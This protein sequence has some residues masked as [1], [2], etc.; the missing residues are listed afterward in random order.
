MDNKSQA[1]VHAIHAVILIEYSESLNSFIN[2][3]KY[4]CKACELD[5]KTP[6]WFHINA[7][8]M[9][10]QRQFV[11]T[12]KLEIANIGALYSYEELCPT[13]NDINLAIRQAVLCLDGKRTCSVHSLVL[14]ALNQFSPMEIQPL[15]NTLPVIKPINSKYVV[16][17]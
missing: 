3:C 11:L 15:P 16:R 1:A 13:E 5:P 6:Q 9:A 2:A 4:A 14:T 8:V 17:L 7:L 10:A 12:H